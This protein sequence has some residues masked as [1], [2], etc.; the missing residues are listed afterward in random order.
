[1]KICRGS[2]HG[3]VGSALSHFALLT[4]RARAIGAAIPTTAGFCESGPV[5]IVTEKT[6]SL[7][8]GEFAIGVPICEFR[9]RQPAGGLPLS[10]CP[11]L[12]PVSRYF[13]A[14]LPSVLCQPGEV[15][16]RRLETTSSETTT[17]RAGIAKGHML[18]ATTKGIACEC[19]IAVRGPGTELASS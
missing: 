5:K 10:Y 9:S 7:G 14:S 13:L 18:I 8:P 15:E 12:L 6:R 3:C 4:L 17:C 19:Q 16:D 1:M 2:V 11:E